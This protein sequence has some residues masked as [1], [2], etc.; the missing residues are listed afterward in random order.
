LVLKP[1]KPGT[2]FDFTKYEH[3]SLEDESQINE[4]QISIPISI[5]G[6]DDPKYQTTF[7]F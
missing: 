7:G 4:S 6:E 5:P 2:K 3:R 1:A